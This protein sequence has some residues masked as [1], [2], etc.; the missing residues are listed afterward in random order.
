MWEPQ[1]ETMPRSQLKK[2]QLERL[3]HQVRHAYQQVPFYHTR[4]QEAGV[5]PDDIKSL[6]DITRLPF[7]NKNDFRDNYPYGLM[8]VP[9]SQVVRVHASSGT[10]GKPIIAP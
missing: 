2:L 5:T 1:Y 3:K 10:T 6:E 7:T 9:L 4:F 8:A